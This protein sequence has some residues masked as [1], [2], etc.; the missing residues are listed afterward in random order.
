MAITS[1]SLLLAYN[2]CA[3]LATKWANILDSFRHKSDKIQKEDLAADAMVEIVDNLT[4]TD[5]DK[6]LS[7][8]QGKVLDEKITALPKHIV[9]DNSDL[10]NSILNGKYPIAT[11]PIGSTHTDTNVDWVGVYRRVT[12]TEWMFFAN[13]AALELYFNTKYLKKTEIVPRQKLI[14]ADYQITK[15]DNGFTLVFDSP[16]DI[17]VTTLDNKIDTPNGFECF[18]VS[19]GVGNVIFT[20]GQLYL[21]GT[22]NYFPTTQGQINLSHPDGS[23][24]EQTKIGSLV[25]FFEL[26]S[27]MLKGQFS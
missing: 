19:I 23:I 18:F 20:R 17:T 11:H 21:V 1:K 10:D 2:K 9:G 14:T 24:L 5:T 13:Q 15:E 25:R 22:T 4:S 12:A 8:N 7:A 26:N 3:D 16:A 27:Y 6:A